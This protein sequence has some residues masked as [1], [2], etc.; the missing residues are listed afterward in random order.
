MASRREMIVPLRLSFIIASKFV[1]VDIVSNEVM[2][3]KMEAT[4]KYLH[5]HNTTRM[6]KTATSLP[7]E[8]LYLWTHEAMFRFRVTPEQRED[9]NI[10]ILM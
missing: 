2:S 6:C 8:T 1:D 5:S 10:P 3:T 7:I 9:A 4:T